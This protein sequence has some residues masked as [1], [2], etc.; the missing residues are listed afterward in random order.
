MPRDAVSPG[1]GALYS[2]GSSYSARF[3]VLPGAQG[4]AAIPGVPQIQQVQQQARQVQQQA[5]QTY[6]QV[7]QTAQ[8]AQ[9]YAQQAQQA[10]KQAGLDIPG[11]DSIAKELNLE[12]PGLPV[13]STTIMGLVTGDIKVEDIV[14]EAAFQLT[15]AIIPGMGVVLSAVWPQIEKIG[16]AAIDVATGQKEKRD[17]RRRNW[18]GIRGVFNYTMDMYPLAIYKGKGIPSSDFLQLFQRN[19]NN[20]D[21]WQKVYYEAKWG[22]HKNKVPDWLHSTHNFQLDYEGSDISGKRTGVT[23]FDRA[24]WPREILK[25]MK[26]YYKLPG[27]EQRK[28]EAIHDA[29]ER[30]K[31]SAQAKAKPATPAKPSGPSVNPLVVRQ[32]QSD[33][34]KIIGGL[35]KQKPQLATQGAKLYI[36]DMIAWLNLSKKYDPALI[37]KVVYQDINKAAQEYLRQN[38]QVLKQIF[39]AAA[40]QKAPQQQKQAQTITRAAVRPGTPANKQVTKALGKKTEELQKLAQKRARTAQIAQKQQQSFM[41]DLRKL[42]QKYAAAKTQQEKDRIRSQLDALSGEYQRVMRAAAQGQELARNTALQKD[43]AQKITSAVATGQPQ[44]AAQLTQAYN[45]VSRS[46]IGQKV[47]QKFL[48]RRVA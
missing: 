24:Q 12:I 35:I 13:S 45:R 39:Q 4:L 47:L 15:N 22:E 14:R 10:A 36:P 16:G 8:Q 18:S 34:L 20:P 27:K 48:P 7:Q 44:K 5:Q 9:S 28:N 21:V 6:Q 29:V 30:A 25:M 19:M 31:Q 46:N 3:P 11:V 17:R 40:Q 1:G 26:D 37:S 41:A 33:M 38:P 2:G 42:Q 43:I 32:I 23:Y